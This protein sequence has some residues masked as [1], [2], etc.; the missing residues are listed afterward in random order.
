MKRV[1]HL[2]SRAKD[3]TPYLVITT[4]MEMLP[5]SGPVFL[6]DGAVRPPTMFVVPASSGPRA[7]LRLDN[8]SRRRCQPR[9]RSRTGFHNTPPLRSVA[10]PPILWMET[11]L[12][13]LSLRDRSNTSGLHDLMLSLPHLAQRR[14]RTGLPSCTRTLRIP[15]PSDNLN[16]STS[17]RTRLVRVAEDRSSDKGLMRSPPNMT[18]S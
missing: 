13:P 10:I 6:P 5:S 7:P 11:V 8:L 17:F 3:N 12:R 14:H 18:R 1:S 2:T 9:S 15:R 16:R 4:Q